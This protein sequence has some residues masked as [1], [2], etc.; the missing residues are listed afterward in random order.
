MRLYILK[1]VS[2]D[3]SR[4]ECS[5]LVYVKVADNLGTATKFLARDESISRQS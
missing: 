3:N 4:K 5:D 2:N 1:D